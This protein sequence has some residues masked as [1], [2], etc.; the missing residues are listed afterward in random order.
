MPAELWHEVQKGQ[1]LNDVGRYLYNEFQKGE[2]LMPADICIRFKRVNNCCLQIFDMRFK[3]VNNWCL[4][5]FVWGSKG[6]TIYAC[7]SLTWGSKGSTIDACRFWFKRVNNWCLQIIDMRFKRVNNWYLQIFVWG[8][9]GA[10]IDACRYLTWG[11]KGWTIDHDA[12]RYLYE[13]QKGQHK[14]FHHDITGILL[15]VALNT[16]KQTNKPKTDG[17]KFVKLDSES[18]TSIEL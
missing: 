6:F 14:T 4:H 16:I 10:T 18:L 3:R 2:Q 12:F 9:K 15:K 11:S 17:N 5:I 1:P 7:W 8:W 13:V